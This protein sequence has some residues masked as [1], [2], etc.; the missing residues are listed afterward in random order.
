MPC[1]V[2]SE[3]NI[4]PRARRRNSFMFKPKR[5]KNVA[6]CF[7]AVSVTPIHRPMMA[8]GDILLEWLDR[9]PYHRSLK[10][11]LNSLPC[12]SEWLSPKPHRLV[13]DE[14]LF[15][16]R[17]RCLDVHKSVAEIRVR[18]TDSV[19]STSLSHSQPLTPKHSCDF[20]HQLVFEDWH[21]TC[22]LSL[23]LKVFACIL[24]SRIDSRT[25]VET[26]RPIMLTA[27]Q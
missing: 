7:H 12:L 19:H 14:R 1:I 24:L 26:S 18:S 27:V 4:T 5:L 20:V 15:R 16:I 10:Q 6:S 13:N 25:F 8:G 23:F 11:Y 21:A 3:S 17:V 22:H 2:Y 9:W